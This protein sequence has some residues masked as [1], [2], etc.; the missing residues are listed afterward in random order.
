MKVNTPSIVPH[1]IPKQ[2]MAATTMQKVF[3]L[4]FFNCEAARN[5]ASASASSMTNMT[6]P[7]VPKTAPIISAS[8]GLDEDAGMAA[9][10]APIPA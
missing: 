6:T 1:G 5:F 9:I 4:R 7:R 3:D 2:V 8:C 10:I